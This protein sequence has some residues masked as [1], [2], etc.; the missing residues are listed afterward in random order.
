MGEFDDAIRWLEKLTGD[1]LADARPVRVR[2]VSVSEPAG[3]GRYQECRVGL[4]VEGK[5]AAPVEVS[6]VLPVKRWPTVG[7]VLP[8]RAS[9][10]HPDAIGVDWE[11][12]PA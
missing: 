9:R 3:R 4:V 7:L 12:L 2:T 1:P 10:T 11:R 6:V 5:D 8:A